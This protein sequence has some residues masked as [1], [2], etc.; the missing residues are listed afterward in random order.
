MATALNSPLL[1]SQLRN[2]EACRPFLTIKAGK[3]CLAAGA[4]FAAVSD[5]DSCLIG[6]LSVL[7]KTLLVGN[8]NV[9]Y[10]MK[11][12]LL[13]TGLMPAFDRQVKGGLAAAGVA[14]VDK[15]RYLL[16]ALG[17][18]DAK[19]ICALPFYIADCISRQAAV[20]AREVAASY[21][22]ALASEH[23]RIFDVLFF[24]QND[25]I[26]VTVHFAPP[27]DIPW[28]AIK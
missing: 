2:L 12:M 1:H 13:L 5:F 18:S 19:K 11:L 9:T 21:Y 4:P 10:P 17:S 20:I 3:R 28:Y 23:G 6:T 16:A 7:S 22:P 14:G 15:T 25:T 27:A 24:M 8:T 26:H